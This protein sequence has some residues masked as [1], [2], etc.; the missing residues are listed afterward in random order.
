MKKSL[1]QL[2]SLYPQILTFPNSRNLP[3]ASMVMG[4]ACMMGHRDVAMEVIA[5]EPDVLAWPCVVYGMW[6]HKMPPLQEK[7][8]PL[9]TALHCGNFDIWL[10]IFNHPDFDLKTPA[11]ENPV[12]HAPRHYYSLFFVLS[13]YKVN[14]E[15][16]LKVFESLLAR[17]GTVPLVDF[18]TAVLYLAKKKPDVAFHVLDRINLVMEVE[19]PL[20]S[21][22]MLSVWPRFLALPL[23]R[24][25]FKSAFADPLDEIMSRILLSMPTPLPGILGLA[26]QHHPEVVAA[27]ESGHLDKTL[28]PGLFPPKTRRL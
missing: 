7:M 22:K 26:R 9:E 12:H 15:G 4:M 17:G 28:T 18:L 2:L 23:S 27:M 1:D 10:D 13:N 21:E 14:P 11:A 6:L 8:F 16:A 3:L 25:R 24:K 20:F 19:H 5:L